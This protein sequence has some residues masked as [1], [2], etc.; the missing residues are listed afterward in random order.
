MNI[1]HPI[2]G[3]RY[4][5]LSRQ[6]KSLLKKYIRSYQA[7]ESAITQEGGVLLLA[8]IL[9]ERTKALL[10]TDLWKKIVVSTYDTPDPQQSPRTL[11][12]DAFN[13]VRLAHIFKKDFHKIHKNLHADLDRIIDKA[14]KYNLFDNGDTKKQQTEFLTLIV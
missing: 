6:G 4:T 8:N 3:V 13:L 2:T 12:D 7:G 10:E 14:I 1:I 9:K 5:L 11:K